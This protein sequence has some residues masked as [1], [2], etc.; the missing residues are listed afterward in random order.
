MTGQQVQHFADKDEM[1]ITVGA[2]VPGVST[3]GTFYFRT[4]TPG[5][6]NQRLYAKNAGTWT[7]IL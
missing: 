4:D 1:V 3:P 7:G 2:G 5:T 6:V